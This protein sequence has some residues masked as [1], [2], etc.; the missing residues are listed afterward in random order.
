MT[1]LSNL[2][3]IPTTDAAIEQGIIAIA[4][5]QGR[6]EKEERLAEF[7]AT[8]EGRR[9]INWCYNPF[10]T[11]G[12]TWKK[13]PEYRDGYLDDIAAT[14][15]D[16]NQ[17]GLV[18][19]LLASL[20][21]RELTGNAAK[22]AVESAFKALNSSAAKILW[23]C[24]NKDLKAGVAEA[25]IRSIDPT[26][27][28][29][30]SVMRAHTYEDKLVKKFPVAVEPKLD[31][32]RVSFISRDGSG[33]FF[34]R[35]GKVIASLDHMVPVLLNMLKGWS[36]ETQSVGQNDPLNTFLSKLVVCNGIPS[37]MLDGEMMSDKGF[38]DVNGA[39]NRKD[40]V[41]G[42]SF[43]IFD[44]LSWEEFDAMGSVNEPYVQR[45]RRVGSI[46]TY[47]S[48]N[49]LAKTIRQTPV[50]VCKTHD[51]IMDWYQRFRDQ[52]YEG[53]MVK[54]PAGGYDKKKSRAWLKLKAEDTEDLSI[55]GVFQGQAD[56]KYADTI[57][58]IIVDRNGVEVRVSG[59]DDATRAEIWELWV[60]TAVACGFDPD[61]GY[62]GATFKSQIELCGVPALLL[63]RV[64]EVEFHEVT[65]DGSLRHPRFIRFRD[66]KTGEVD[67]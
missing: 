10:I 32:N 55:I 1:D 52:G 54:D 53:A 60:E 41:H 15:S 7:A 48:G 49:G 11:F 16:W 66:D 14:E 4:T 45:R 51:E 35:T 18:H 6:N 31:G 9:I 64:V 39:L 46:V 30:F 24:L 44:V 34:T 29:I 20:A 37:L 26:L 59:L 42:L 21:S 61:V 22:D 63:G 5:A 65:K 67:K 19:N 58:G 38:D 62:E 56:G 8:E 33:G 36:A 12:V 57:G 43:H 2:P 13:E 25:S 28:P 47:A 23:L 27:I 50:H 17:I 3:K 40:D